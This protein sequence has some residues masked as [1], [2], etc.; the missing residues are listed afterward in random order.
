[1]TWEALQQGDVTSVVGG[2]AQVGPSAFQ[3]IAPATGAVIGTVGGADGGQVTEAVTVAQEAQEAWRARSPEDRA[4]V[5]EALADQIEQ[6]ADVLAA[7]ESR[8]TGKPMALARSV[9]I[10][11]AVHNFRFFAGAV[12]H[13]A[14]ECHITGGQALNYTLRRPLGVVAL[15]TPWNLPLYLLSWKA[16]PA[17]AMGNA[18]VAKPSEMTPTTAS[19]LAWLAQAAG[20]PDGVF[21]VVQGLG[22][23]AGGALVGDSRVR[24][25]S[26]TGGTTTGRRIAA[27]AA[28]EGLKKVSLELG[29]KNPSIVFA[30]CDF[31]STLEGVIRAALINQGQICLCGSRVLVER[32][33]MPRFVDA[34]ESR[35]R[36][37]R[38]GDPADPATELGALISAAHRDKV[39]GYIALAQE[40]GG[41]V[42]C[43]GRRPAL[44]EALRGGFFLEPTLITDLAPG[45]RAACEEIFG[46]VLTVHP[47]D[48]DAEALT[49]ANAT[50]YG[51]AASVWT[52]DLDRAHALGRDLD[53]GMVWVNT[54]ML[55]D[56]RVPFGGMK[57][58]GVGREG[59]IYSMDFF[60]EARN[61]CI[62]WR[63]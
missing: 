23:E 39:E 46:P 30:D 60:S 29:G 24:G 33:L 14:T 4:A 44:T 55:R 47:F 3:N 2:R 15:I 35:F 63:S 42:V 1:M 26:F 38:I 36:T 10:P 12:R 61:V 19:A 43:G 50:P 20:V 13:D 16:A 27:A 18:V 6:H 32:S 52:Q 37:K 51:L 45:S 62:A 56:S 11:R 31:E 40:A 59:G 8:D 34:L 25:V 57:D 54:W 22:P 5:L 49:L 17:L 9:D 53:A 7:W 28:A 58:S 41:R 21:N 48:T